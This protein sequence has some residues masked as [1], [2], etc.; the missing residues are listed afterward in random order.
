MEANPLAAPITDVTEIISLGICTF[1]KANTSI[2]VYVT[3]GTE[4]K[5]FFID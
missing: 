1:N 5:S 3:K 2:P 4:E